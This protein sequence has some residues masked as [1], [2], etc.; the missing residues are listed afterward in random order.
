MNSVLHGN[1]AHS[2]INA[3]NYELLVLIGR[4]DEDGCW[5][6]KGRF[7][8]EQGVVIQKALKKAMDEQFAE[9]QDG[10]PHVSQAAVICLT[11]EFRHEG[12][13]CQGR[14]AGIGLHC[15][16]GCRVSGAMSDSRHSE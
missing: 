16:R 7:T 1:R 14:V 6:M 2:H 4:Y 12:H 8:P 11:V 13:F 9:P 3:A 10:H 15:C 5:V